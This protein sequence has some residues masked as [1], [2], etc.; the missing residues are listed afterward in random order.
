M[1]LTVTWNKA[2]P[3]P[4]RVKVDGARGPAMGVFVVVD[5][6]HRVNEHL[7]RRLL[8]SDLRDIVPVLLVVAAVLAIVDGSNLQDAEAALAIAVERGG[9]PLRSSARHSIPDLLGL[10][11]GVVC[12]G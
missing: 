11:V 5:V 1:V 8:D 6:Q 7:I 4:A 2:S 12:D 9:A 10:W 3:V